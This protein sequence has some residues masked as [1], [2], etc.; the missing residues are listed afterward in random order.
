MSRACSSKTQKA[1]APAGSQPSLQPFS[2][3]IRQSHM[4]Y[5]LCGSCLEAPFSSQHPLALPEPITPN[6][7][8]R[9]TLLP[10]LFQSPCDFQGPRN[11]KSLSSVSSGL[12]PWLT[13]GWALWCDTLDEN[14]SDIPTASFLPPLSDTRPPG[15]GL[16][17][18]LNV[19]RFQRAETVSSIQRSLHFMCNVYFNYIIILYQVL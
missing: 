16:S 6:P 14:L 4:A 15:Q 18:P 19:K 2:D 10:I 5:S 8:A 7:H 11:Q 13:S 17:Q 9:L 3:L 1:Q 12:C